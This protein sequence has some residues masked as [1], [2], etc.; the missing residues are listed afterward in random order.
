MLCRSQTKCQRKKKILGKKLFV[1]RNNPIKPFINFSFSLRNFWT[2]TS[3]SVQ[4]LWA[5]IVDKIR[6]L[7]TWLTHTFQRIKTSCDYCICCSAESQNEVTLDAAITSEDP[8]SFVDM[9]F[10][11]GDFDGDFEPDPKFRSSLELDDP[12][13]YN[14]QCNKPVK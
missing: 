2:N 13:Y 7:G 10:D 12:M 11:F 14:V 5:S 4:L 9:S 8:H 6:A 3:V 1:D